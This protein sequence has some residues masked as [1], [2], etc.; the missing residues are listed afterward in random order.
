MTYDTLAGPARLEQEIRKSRFLA[1]AAPVDDIQ[2]AMDFLA[3]QRINDASHHCWAYKLGNA[4]RFNDDGEPAG[5]AGK[6]IL[7]AIEGQKLDYVTV[8]IIRWFGGVKLG[9]GGL[10]RAYGGTAVECLRTAPRRA[11]VATSRVRFLCSYHEQGAIRQRLTGAEASDITPMFDAD[12]IVFTASVPQDGCDALRDAIADITRGK[13][14][15]QDDR[16]DQ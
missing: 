3:T 9:A 13:S 11:V 5:T 8:V 15:W 6:P 16:T 12:G 7:Q 10:V 4:Y 1:L 14:Q 2:Q